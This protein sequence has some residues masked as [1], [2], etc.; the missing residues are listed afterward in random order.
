VSVSVKE[1]APVA[2]SQA[3]PEDTRE[4]PLTQA[5]GG[6]VQT[7]VEPTQAPLPLQASGEE[8]ALPSSQA[9]PADLGA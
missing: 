6:G 2:A 9:A 7:R 4:A 8:Q 3:P 5:G 1:Q